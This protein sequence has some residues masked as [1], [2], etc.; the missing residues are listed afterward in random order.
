MKQ[1]ETVQPVHQAEIREEF[2]WGATITVL[3]MLL[4]FIGATFYI[5]VSSFNELS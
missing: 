5:L 1:I 3:L 2:N 4:A